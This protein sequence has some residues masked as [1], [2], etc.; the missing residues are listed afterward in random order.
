MA[1][2]PCGRLLRLALVL[3][4]LLGAALA[5]AQCTP[6]PSTSVLR[7]KGFATAYFG[8]LRT[9]TANDA[10]ELYGGVCLQGEGTAWTLRAERVG[11]RGLSGALEVSADGPTLSFEGWQVHAATLRS[12]SRLLSLDGV[13]LSGHDVVGAADALTL[14]LAS[15]RLQLSALTLHGAAFYLS[16]SGATLDGDHLSVQAPSITSCHCTGSPLYHVDGVSAQVDLK[17]QRI[18]LKGGVLF[19]AGVP[20]PLASPLSVDASS[21]AKLTLPV[22]VSYV[23]TDATTGTVGTGLGVVLTHLGLAPGL[24][25][26]LGATG[27]DP[28]YPPAGV[29]LLDG[30]ANGASFSFG[31]A[32]GGLHFEL[33]SDHALA[34]WL[35]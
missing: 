15:G 2:A 16:G 17:G 27:L 25:A 21:L 1:C 8:Q 19:F 32:S 31:T 33:T 3:L 7:L 12:T 34:P 30:H 23:A 18:V 10:A 5:Q 26:Q 20:V 24:F 6:G 4:A 11:L 29:A 14:D 9:D 13:S 28:A 35:D 22:S